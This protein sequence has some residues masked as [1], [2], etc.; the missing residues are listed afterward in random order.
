FG[1][2]RNKC[3]LPLAGRPLVVYSLEALEAAG[4]SAVVVVVP[5]GEEAW[6]RRQLELHG[7][8]R[9]VRVVPGGPRRQDSVR[10]GL[11]ALVEAV[12]E[13]ALVVVHDGARP[14][15]RPSLVD[16]VVVAARR[17]GA[18]VPGVPVVDTVK[19][20]DGQGWVAATPA[21]DGLVAVQ[22]PQAFRREL[23]EA[24]HVRAVAE[25]WECSDDA[26]LV[27]RN[28]GGVRVVPGDV[29]NL[30]VTWPEDLEWAECLLQRRQGAAS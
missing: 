11:Q 12:G 4:V 13:V 21:R 24:A 18:A 2:G 25:G 29:D 19:R 5:A 14:L 27:E 23:L 15:V 9:I 17:W 8:K 26:G 30:K 10:L 3:F 16:R 20:V 1:A 7:L 6:S 22:T 28:G